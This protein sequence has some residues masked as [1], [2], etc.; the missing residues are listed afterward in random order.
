MRQPHDRGLS[1]IENPVQHR[2]LSR[3][4][5][6]PIGDD[7]LVRADEVL[8]SLREF[9]VSSRVAKE[10]L[11]IRQSQFS[12]FLVAVGTLSDRLADEAGV[13]HLTEL[14]RVRHRR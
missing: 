11:R 9:V 5:L 3:F 4:I 7:L 12:T 2:I 13:C 1:M 10:Q 8:F 6:I 14:S